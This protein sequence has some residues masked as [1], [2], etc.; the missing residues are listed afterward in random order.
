MFLNK[1]DKDGKVVLVPPKEPSMFAKFVKLNYKLSKESGCNHA[2][3]MK[4]L[5]DNFGKLTVQEKMKYKN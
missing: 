4:I 1:T 5:S 2:A 3:V